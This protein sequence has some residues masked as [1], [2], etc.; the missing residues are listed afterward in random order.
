M[1]KLLNFLHFYPHFI[2]PEA[3]FATEAFPQC[4][5]YLYMVIYEDST[6]F[7]NSCVHILLTWDKVVADVQRLQ[8]DKSFKWIDWRNTANKS[9]TKLNK[10]RP[11]GTN[12]SIYNDLFIF[13]SKLLFQNI[14]ECRSKWYPQCTH[15]IFI[16]YYT[17]WFSSY[18][19]YILNSHLT[20]FRRS[21]I[22]QSVEHCTGIA[23]VMGSNPVGA[24][25]F[26]LG[27]I[28]NSLSYFMTARITCTCTQMNFQ[29]SSSIFCFI[30]DSRPLTRLGHSP[31]LTDWEVL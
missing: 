1:F 6:F 19:T 29:V 7:A 28:C 25:E 14:L 21:F 23:E 16:I 22:A 20:C 24:S 12:N 18:N 26:F 3:C 31:V 27:F 8:H 2:F 30:F 11:A 17:H 4:T 9:N 5:W 15:M 10:L 13:Y